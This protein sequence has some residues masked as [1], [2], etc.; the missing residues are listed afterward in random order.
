MRF[1][2]NGTPQRSKNGYFLIA[3]GSVR[4][5][6]GRADV[7]SFAYSV[8]IPSTMACQSKRDRQCVRP[9]R[10]RL[11]RVTTRKLH[12]VMISVAC[13]EM[14]T[15]VCDFKIHHR[16]ARGGDDPGRT[17]RDR[18]RGRAAGWKNPTCLRN[19][20]SPRSVPGRTG[21]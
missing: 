18:G 2:R 3:Q 12:G 8:S 19:R 15:C 4:W 21:L 14:R 6:Y 16:G 5:F 7:W 9:C 17:G 13:W 10:P 20:A 1:G 11:R